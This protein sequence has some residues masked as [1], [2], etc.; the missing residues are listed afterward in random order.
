MT[1]A[2]RALDALPHDPFGAF[3]RDYHATLEGTRGG[4]LAGLS[5]AAKDVFD[6]AGRPRGFGHPEWTSSHPPATETAEALRLLLD[7]GASLA[8][9][10]VSDE[11]CYS[12]TGDNVHYG[13]P[14]NPRAPDRVTGG[15]SSG[16]AAVVAGGLVDFAIGT[17]CGGSVRVPSAYC[18]IFGMRPTHGRASLEG[19]HPFAGSFDCTGWMA[20]D[21]ELMTRVGRVLLRDEAPA[22][23]FRRLVIAED[24]MARADA[25]V[26]GGLEAGV[27]SLSAAV[28]EAAQVTLAPEGL[29]SWFETFRVLQ[30][31]EIWAAL[32]T[33]IATRQPRFG[34]GVA[35]R[36]AAAS[37]IGSADVAAATRRREEIRLRLDEAIGPDDVVC[38]PTTPR[39]APPRGGAVE[40]VEVDF[41]NRAMA[42]LCVAGLGGL[43]QVT[44]P[45]GTVGGAPI[46]LSVIARR[47]RDIDLLDLVGR[48][49]LAVPA[50]GA[51]VR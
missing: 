2:Q 10:T 42:L 8:G 23:P 46:G 29:E 50:A 33:W 40:E 4:P 49:F 31:G 19:V 34:P 51:A 38:L 15:S 21:P 36:F 37:R 44:V 18:G 24:G 32:G 30:A 47:G 6:I 26:R 3:C 11:M 39:P 25:D 48:A 9:R 5:F 13:A 43:P 7:A 16:S 28:G 35:E 22:R 1:E 12:L 27:S 45:A 14:I 17:D 20:R 41:R